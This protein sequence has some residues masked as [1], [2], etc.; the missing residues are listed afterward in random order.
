MVL[1]LDFS[2]AYDQICWL[3]IRLMLLHVGFRLALVRFIMECITLESFVV[4]V[5]ESAS[6]C[7]R[8]FRGLIKGCHHSPLIFLLVV[9]CL[10][11]AIKDAKIQRLI[12]GVKGEIYF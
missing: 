8:A 9:E 2:K 11:R 1:K 5:N 3:Y 6:N 12:V 4:L 10:S 7:F